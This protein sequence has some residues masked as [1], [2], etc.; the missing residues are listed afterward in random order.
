MN[1]SRNFESQL[2]AT[3]A[4]L[5]KTRDDAKRLEQQLMD[6]HKEADSLA[7]DL[8]AREAELQK[9]E[10]KEETF[11]GQLSQAQDRFND[12][13]EETHMLKQDKEKLFG[14]L[15]H[16]LYEN[17]NLRNE[18]YMMKRMMLEMEKKEVHNDKVSS[19]LEQKFADLNS[20]VE[21]TRV[22]DDE[23]EQMRNRP[24]RQTLRESAP[25]YD[26]ET[27]AMRNPTRNNRENMGLGSPGRGQ[28]FPTSSSGFSNLAAGNRQSIGS[29]T[30]GGFRGGRPSAPPE[31]E[32]PRFA[33]PGRGQ[34]NVNR[35]NQSS[36]DI[37]NLGSSGGQQRQGMTSP[38]RGR[39]HVDPNATANNFMA[40]QQQMMNN[41]PKERE[42]RVLD[43]Q[44]A[45]L[46]REHDQVRLMSSRPKQS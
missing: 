22:V 42:R 37:F 45:D 28:A 8:K 14:K 17:E 41:D 40:Q 18:L 33:S 24:E 35:A 12:A 16:L 46:D 7:K 2:Q 10:Y 34:M 13:K 21:R 25:M 4:E 36:S 44:L 38:P 6:T 32:P 29:P 9:M 5:A 30:D 15:D 43:A 26:T 3:Q 23:I 1:R 31:P 39:G 11:R 20:R 27:P 19:L